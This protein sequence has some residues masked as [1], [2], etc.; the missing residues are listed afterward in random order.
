M[1]T[2]K[3]FMKDFRFGIVAEMSEYVSMTC[4]RTKLPEMANWGCED[5]GYC[6]N[7]ARW[8]AER[9]TRGRRKAKARKTW[10]LIY[11]V[12]LVD[13]TKVTGRAQMKISVITSTAVMPCQRAY[14]DTKVRIR[15]P[16]QSAA[17]ENTWIPTWPGQVVTSLIVNIVLASQLMTMASIDP[18]PHT[19]L[20]IK[21]PKQSSH[22][23]S[24]SM[25][26]TRKMRETTEHLARHRMTI[27]KISEA[28]RLYTGC[29]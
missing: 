11:R 21:V 9:Y 14:C 12:M 27:D 13:Q 2:E 25:V 23:R 10:N 18:S 8:T 1:P 24:I 7:R 6:L 5:S 26:K 28:K 29:Q 15:Y 19:A 22:V 20:I 17:R 4:C 3:D 16:C